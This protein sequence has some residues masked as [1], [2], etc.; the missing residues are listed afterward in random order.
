[1]GILSLVSV[2]CRLVD[3]CVCYEMIPGQEESYG[4]F[5]CYCAWPGATETLYVYSEYVEEARL[6]ER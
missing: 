3:R 1:M 5:V 6:R 4:M 2:V